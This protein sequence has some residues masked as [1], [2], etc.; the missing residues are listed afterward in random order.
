MILVLILAGCSPVKYLERHPEVCDLCKTGDV[1]VVTNT[2]T[3]RDTLFLQDPI[4]FSAFL[5][6][7]SNYNVVLNQSYME[8]IKADSAR[9][10]MENNILTLRA[11]LEKCK[12]KII[13]KTEY[14]DREVTVKEPL[15]TKLQ[16]DNETL[17][18]KIES[19]NDFIKVLLL[20]LSAG[21]ILFLVYVKILRK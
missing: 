11:L 7:D 5:S 18:T 19:K 4:L 1:T 15:N 8:G 17:K 16:A 9:L 12:G 14:K 6:C 20:I 3:E 10:T 21:V 2:V 13:V